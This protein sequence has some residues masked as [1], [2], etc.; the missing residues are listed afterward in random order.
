MRR[1]D[2]G[3]CFLVVDIPDV[4]RVLHGVVLLRSV[5]EAAAAALAVVLAEGRLNA[6][7]ATVEVRLWEESGGLLFS[8]AD[9][10][11]GFDAALARSGHGYTNMADRLGAIGGTVRWDSVPGAGTTISG[12]VPLL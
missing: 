9:D 3:D 1:P 10:G 4:I 11:P 5:T 7:D 6:T 2:R 12:S 8:V